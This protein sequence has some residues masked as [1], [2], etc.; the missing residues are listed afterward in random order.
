MDFGS[1]RLKP[2]KK[3]ASRQEVLAQAAAD[4]V[5]RAAL[6]E[7]DTAATKL[8]AW[9]RGQAAATQARAAQLQAFDAR[10]QGLARVKLQLPPGAR[11]PLPPLC[12]LARSL[13]FVLT[14]RGSSRVNGVGV[15]GGDGVL[16]GAAAVKLRATLS[17]LLP[18]LGS[19]NVADA[20]PPLTPG[21]LCQALTPPEAASKAERKA[22]ELAAGVPRTLC[23]VALLAVC[24]LA[25]ETVPRG[26]AGPVA[27][28]DAALAEANR[29]GDEAASDD[30]DDEEDDDGGGVDSSSSSSSSAAAGAS[31][32]SAGVAVVPAASEGKWGG[33]LPMAFLLA[34]LPRLGPRAQQQLLAALHGL[35]AAARLG[36]SRSGRALAGR[37]SLLRVAVD[38]L[39]ALACRKSSPSDNLRNGRRNSG[40]LRRRAP[41]GEALGPVARRRLGDLFLLTCTALIRP[42]AADA[43]GPFTSPATAAAVEG[44][45]GALA[46]PLPFLP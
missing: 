38:A 45:G 42:A 1:A 6:R 4:R 11:L 15:I 21:S 14:G 36:C 37:P 12:L 28:A 27:H 35:A 16:T 31:S 39:A 10:L 46:S 8:Q 3:T 30:D 24:L 20:P 9:R 2:G 32:G 43:G 22:A 34:V 26:A 33:D 19:G 40:S 7:R 41:L 25:A 18:A 13:A 23:R 44:G 5:Q 29:G 17:L